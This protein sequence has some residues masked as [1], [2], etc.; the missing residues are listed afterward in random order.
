MPRNPGSKELNE[1]QREGITG[2]YVEE[3]RGNAP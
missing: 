3:V 2:Q 1:F